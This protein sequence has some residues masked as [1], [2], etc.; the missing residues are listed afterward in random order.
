MATP[1]LVC[2]ADLANSLIERTYFDKCNLV[3]TK[4][5]DLINSMSLC[6]FTMDIDD[7]ATSRVRI[8]PGSA[9]LVDDAGLGTYYG[10]AKFLLIK[11]TYPATFT[12]YS[13][14]YINLNYLDNIYPIGELHIWTGNPSQDPGSGIIIT[15]DTSSNAPNPTYD[16]G[17]IVLHNPHYNYVDVDIMI[18]SSVPPPGAN[19][20][21]NI[22]DDSEG[23]YILI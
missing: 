5:N 16:L 14:R 13:D 11:V 17:G 4:G 9:F 15:P 20:D 19:L 3:I 10:E 23:N 12:N 22:L 6:D 2:S 18:A 1:P 7:F 8:R 21:Q